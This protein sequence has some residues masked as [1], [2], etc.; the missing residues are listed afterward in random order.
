VL[1]S[2][3][4]LLSAAIPAFTSIARESDG[5]PIEYDLA[6]LRFGW[7]QNSDLL[8]AWIELNDDNQDLLR[9]WLDSLDLREVAVADALSG[10]EYWSLRALAV[11][12]FGLT[13]GE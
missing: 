7:D 10:D 4:G 12:H 8:D 13:T 1:V 3:D 11:K 5:E 6:P 9:S 2:K